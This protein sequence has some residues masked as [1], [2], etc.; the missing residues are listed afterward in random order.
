MNKKINVLFD[1]TVLENGVAKSAAR[2]GVYFVAYNILLELLKRNELQVSLYSDTSIAHLV[3]EIIKSDPKLKNVVFE[4]YSILDKLIIKWE[5]LKYR[6]KVEKGNKILRVGIK[7]IL[8]CL[9]FISDVNNKL[10]IVD[11]SYE[12]LYKNYDVFF[13]PVFVIPEKIRNIAK[14]KKYCILYDII[15]FIY[16]EN[17]SD[18]KDKSSWFCKLVNSIN[19]ED[20]YFAISEYTKQ[21]FI[22][23]VENITP[24][25]ITTI[26][27]STGLKYGKINDQNQIDKVKEKYKIPKN[28]KYLFS[29][30]T[31]E[32]RKNLIFAVQNFIEFIKRDNIDDLVFVLGG[33]HWDIFIQK[34]NEAIEDAE[35]Y[36][37]KIIKIGYV[38]DEDMPALYSG[39]EMFVFPSIYEG[40]GMP[41]LEAMQCGCPVIT[42]NV[43]SMPEVIGDCGIQI[44][45]KDNEDLIN[46]FHKMYFNE[47]FKNECIQKGIER[48]KQ[49]TWKKCVNVITEEFLKN[50]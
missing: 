40:F 20:H 25:H 36:K 3:F 22:K 31:L 24:E 6:N 5:L 46:A 27:L 33:G 19:K 13:S 28:K 48:A 18:M 49:F 43:T 42:S 9:K 29:L 50:A 37:D 30:C 17:Y 38:D 15:P 1:A 12:K 16:P 26:P 7:T 8:N 35:K 23:H 14:L 10:N 39:A 2:S 41:I 47:D 45:P 44:N 11:E 34:L 32:P 4:K 21:D